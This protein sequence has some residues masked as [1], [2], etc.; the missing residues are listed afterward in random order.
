MPTFRCKTTTHAGKIVEETITADSKDSLRNQLES[1][2]KFVL[3]IKKA[4]GFG[5]FLK[6]VKSRGKRFKTKDFFSFNQEFLVL[7]KAGLPIVAALDAI[8]EQ[9]DEG[10]L[11]TLLKDIR[12][13][14]STG[15]SLS[16]A[17]GKYTNL[18]SHLY[19]SSLQTGEKSGDLPIAI[20]RYLEYMKKTDEIKKKVISA[21]VYPVI[22]IVASV[23]VLIFLMIYVV[24]GITSTFLETSTQLPV[25]TSV[26]LSISN[27]IRS[28]FLYIFVL[29]ILTAI[30]IALFRRTEKGRIYIDKLK[31]V[32]PFFGNLY[33]NYSTSKLTRAMAAMLDGG[34]PLVD[35][36]KIS[37]G[38]LANQILKGRLESVTSNLEEGGSFAESLSLV[39][40]FPNMA[41]RMIDAGESGGALEQVLNDVA[42]F[43]DNDV[44]EKLSI[45]TS[46]I[47]PA[48]MVFMGLLIGLIVLALYLPIFQLA[49]TIG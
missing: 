42:D 28:N 46:A 38:A 35:S 47:E 9:E 5:A 29:G 8:I 20:W 33:I 49:G 43:Y 3:D 2:G 10:E 11:N 12:E 40:M 45:M 41:V 1:D 39:E 23:F 24:P 17:F 37:S 36:I 7:I 14:I 16:E 32:I 25:I 27:V 22:L 34:M 19:I 44:D 13:D 18:F 48:L 6:N 21:S 31:L 15:E 30:S 26:L 4:D